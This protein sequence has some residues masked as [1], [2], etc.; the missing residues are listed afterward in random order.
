MSQEEERTKVVRYWWAQAEES[1]AS[2]RREFDAGAYPF[3]VNRLY[4]SAFYAV[5][6][7]LLERQLSFV[8]H[9]GV[10]AAFH[11]EFIKTGLL[12]VTWGKLYDQL[13]ADREEGDY[14]ALI[15][16]DYEYIELQLNRCAEFLATLKP[17]IVSLE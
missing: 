3:A 15:S 6:A 16:F 17:L 10:R 5:S 12:E 13:F 11:R 8:K 1:L 4:Y 7:A 9:S 14:A 2:A